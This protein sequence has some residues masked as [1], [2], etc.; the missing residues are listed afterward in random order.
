MTQKAC[1]AAACRSLVI[2]VWEV[3]C[4]PENLRD[5]CDYMRKTVFECMVLA[6]LTMRGEGRFMSDSAVQTLGDCVEGAMIAYDYLSK[7]AARLGI[8]NWKPIPKMHL[9][10]HSAYDMAPHCNPRHVHG[11]MDEDMVGKVKKIAVRCH[12]S[13]AGMRALQRYVL[14]VGR[15]WFKL[16]AWMRGVPQ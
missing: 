12:P 4:R 13:T 14:R 3:C 11:Y 2:W 5:D 8:R 7:E 9:M 1:K 16:M 15:H 10:E 6:D